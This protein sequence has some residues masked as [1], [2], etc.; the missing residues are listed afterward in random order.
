MFTRSDLLDAIVELTAALCADG[1]DGRAPKGAPDRTVGKAEPVAIK[2]LPVPLVEETPLARVKPRRVF[3]SDW[4]LRRM[5]KPGAKFVR[6]P[7]GSIISPLARDWLDYEGI[8][9]I[10]D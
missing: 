1:P 10:F 6:V 2:P 5:R 3:L 8:E 7:A 4:E 9:V